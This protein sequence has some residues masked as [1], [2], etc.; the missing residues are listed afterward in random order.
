[1]F[2]AEIKGLETWATDIGNAYLEA[3]TTASA[4]IIAGPEFG[5]CEGHTL[6]IFKALYGLRTSGLCVYG[7]ATKMK[8]A[9]IHVRTEEPDFSSLPEQDFDWAYSVYGN[10]REIDLTDIPEALGKYNESTQTAAR[11]M[12]SNRLARWNDKLADC[13]KSP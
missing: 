11:V 3:E 4:Y 9:I 7:Y 8:H 1:V 13:P 12:E 2:L 10:V 6:V 5:E